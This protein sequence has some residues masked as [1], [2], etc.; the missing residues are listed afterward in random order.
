MGIVSNTFYV[1]IL[2]KIGAPPTTNNINIL[3]TWQ[4]HEG[5]TAT[6]N[7]LNTT[8]K[9]VDSTNF[10]SFGVK[11]YGSFNTGTEATA[12]TLLLRYYKPIVNAFKDNEPLAYWRNNPAIRQSLNTWGT[13]NWANSLNKPTTS[14]YSGY[15]GEVVVKPA[16]KDNSKRNKTI[17]IIGGSLVLFTAGSFAYDYYKNRKS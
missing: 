13:V 12:D 5:G 1:H 16:K 10:N 4:N 15:S 2:Q 11:N 17:L 7:P 3:K 8:M 6:Y 14:G 9:D